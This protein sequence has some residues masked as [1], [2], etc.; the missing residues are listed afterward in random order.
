MFAVPEPETF[1]IFNV[2]PAGTAIFTFG[3]N[4]SP[5][6]FANIIGPVRV[7]VEELAKI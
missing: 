7:C 4:V 3:E 6:L 5:T 2:P 1:P